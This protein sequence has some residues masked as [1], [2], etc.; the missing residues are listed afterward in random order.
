MSFHTCA[1]PVHV[2]RVSVLGPHSASGQLAVSSQV[3]VSQAPG[4]PRAQTAQNRQV[5]RGLPH[6][7]FSVDLLA[8]HLP[9]MST[10][11]SVISSFCKVR[12]HEWTRGVA[13][14][15]VFIPKNLVKCVLTF[16]YY[17][18]DIHP[19]SDILQTS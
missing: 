14:E 13:E 16:R 1:A 2:P 11:V 6:S 7:D 18:S 12:A 5:S 15:I 9:G 3:R 4:V 8:G 10:Q 19:I 17:I